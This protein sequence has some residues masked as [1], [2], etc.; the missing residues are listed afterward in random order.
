LLGIAASSLP[1]SAARNAVAVI[2][3]PFI[4]LQFI[5]GVYVPF[6]LIPAWLRDVASVFPLEWICRG[7]RSAFLPQAVALEP[8]HSWQ[9]GL[10]AVVLVAWIAAGLVLCLTTFRWRTSR[11]G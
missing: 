2:S 8:G 5:S 7:M 11:D 1:R 6:T 9:H 4:V 3:L 10:T